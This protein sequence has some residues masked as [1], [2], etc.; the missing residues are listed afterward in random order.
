MKYQHL[1]FYDGECGL[2]DR[3]VQFILEKD[4]DELFCFAPLKGET[5]AKFLKN[6]FNDVDSL[7]LVESY[8]TDPKVFIEGD[9]VFN[10]CSKLPFP[11]YI[12]SKL[13]FFPGCFYNSVYRWVA[14][15]RKQLMNVTCLLPDP[16][17]PERFLK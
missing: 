9:A 10:I 6:N 14:R 4:R 5:A 13:G 2:C 16:K 17:Q 11:Y 3:S 8:K 15:H 7:I 1:V 12:I